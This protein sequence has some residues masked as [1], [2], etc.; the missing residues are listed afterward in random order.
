MKQI[1]FFVACCLIIVSGSAQTLPQKLAAAV[2]KF[3]ADTTMKYA[4]FSLYVVESKTGKL[5][6][7]HHS[8]VGL[9]PASTQ[10]L[11]TSA[12]AFEL[13]GQGYRY[14]TQ[15]GYEGQI[16]GGVLKGNLY[17]T[18]SGD[19]TLGSWRWKETRDTLVIKQLVVDLRKA[20]ITRAIE[21][22]VLP[23]TNRFATQAIPDGW[24]WQ[25]IG[26]YY[27]AGAYGINWKEN[28][29]DLHLRSG[30]DVG[31]SVAIAEEAGRPAR[32][33]NELRSAAKGSGD[34]AYIYLSPSTQ[35]LPLVSGTIPVN[36]KAFSISGASVDPANDLISDLK[37]ALTGV[38]LRDGNAGN[39]K[40]AGASVKPVNREAIKTITT[41]TSPSLDSINYWF[42]RRSINLYGEA[43]VKTLALEKTGYA[44]TDKG[45]ELLR[46]FW[47]QQGINKAAIHI[48][49][50]SG[51]S[52]QNR[53]TTGSLVQVLQYARTRPWY[54]AYYNCLPEFNGMKMKS[55][56]IGG[57][58]AFAGYHTAK[59]GNEYTYAIIVNNYDGSSGD[60]VRKMYQVL[61]LLK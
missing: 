19:P 28:Q 13:L 22:A 21:G 32:Y 41:I 7:D 34:N 38:S 43:L 49:D 55:G 10:K 3:E 20:G 59:D 51:L 37:K 5:V 50:G 40:G 45:I 9:A 4:T 61:N 17:I 54:M 27:G 18:G 25:D 52:P 56:S 58:R 35:H 15:V 33:I 46:D 48:I 60:V 24:I 6:F 30:E 26:N 53:V 8:N 1:V 11:F 36:E 29:Y 44:T 42:L 23:Q 57:A 39:K 31:D 2:E 12:A 47:Q 16:Q 14:H